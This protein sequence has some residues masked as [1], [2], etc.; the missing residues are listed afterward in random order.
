[1]HRPLARFLTLAATF[2]LARGARAEVT[3]EPFV[4]GP[5]GFHVVSALILGDTQA[6]LVDAQFTKSEAHRVVARLLESRREL[7]T[8]YIT[9]A[10]PD[11]F[12]GLEVIKQAFPRA[13]ILAAPVVVT[14]MKK[15]A[16][17]KDKTYR[18][19]YGANLGK[20][21][22]P[23]AYKKNTIDLDGQ[24]IDL[25]PLEP[26]E[27]A[28]AVLVH[29][30]AVKTVIAGDVVFN[31]V[32]PWLAETDA[33]RRAGWLKNL[34]KIKSLSPTTVI[35]G[36]RTPDAKDTPAAVDF[37]A[38]YVADFDKAVAETRSA[39]ELKK[40]VLANAKYK[41]LALPVILDLAAGA[42]FPAPPAAAVPAK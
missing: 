20:P 2:A 37:T 8:V 13:K 16:P 6:V 23:V 31:N 28:A 42:A 7:T 14:E 41:S 18:P 9:H 33:A 25:I 24:T 12:F 19:M 5:D 39:D 22:Y 15:T 27:S 29:V 10:H 30:P 4:A 21:T 17:G 3:V 1:M 32:H 38:A 26:G 40:K 11:H 36:H 35:A 34:E